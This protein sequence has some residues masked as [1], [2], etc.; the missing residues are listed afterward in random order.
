MFFFFWK[1]ARKTTK[2]TRIFYPERTPKIPGKLG[3]NAEKKRNSLE[4]KQQGIPKKQG[5]EDQGKGKCSDWIVRKR[6]QTRFLEG[7]LEGRSGKA[8]VLRSDLRRRIL[9]A[10]A[11]IQLAKH[12][13]GVCIGG[14]RNNRCPRQK[15]QGKPGISEKSQRE[16]IREERIWAI[17]VRRGSYKTL[18]LLN[19]GRKFSS[20]L[21]FA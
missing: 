15:L 4:R 9:T 2:K 1:T 18:F 11:W 6:A 13:V 17:A 12:L 8:S 5:K 16:K 3:E 7:F 19:S 20:E 14:V 10:G 21:Q